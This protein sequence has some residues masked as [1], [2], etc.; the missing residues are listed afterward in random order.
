[1]RCGKNQKKS[2]FKYGSS[3]KEPEAVSITESHGNNKREHDLNW[4]LTR[5]GL[6]RWVDSRKM[7]LCPSGVLCCGRE[8]IWTVD[9][10]TGGFKVK[11]YE[12]FDMGGSLQ[13][14]ES[15][16]NFSTITEK[17]QGH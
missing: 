13:L 9:E 8:D 16:L 4:R 12:I 5:A 1:M 17:R 11:G 15:P 10:G 14:R 3:G 2:L 7:E 6:S